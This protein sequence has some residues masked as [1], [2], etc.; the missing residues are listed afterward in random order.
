MTPWTTCPDHPRSR[1]VY[2]TAF[3]DAAHNR[4]SSPLARGLR[5]QPADRRDGPGI[6]PARAGF[7]TASRTTRSTTWDHP[8]S[9]GVYWR[10][11][12]PPCTPR[13]SSPLARGLLYSAYS[14]SHSPRIIPARAG[15]TDGWGALLNTV[16]DHPR[17]RG[18]YRR[19]GSRRRR[20]SGSSPLARGLLRDLHGEQRRVRIIPARAGYTPRGL[21]A[22][23]QRQDHPRLRGVY[24]VD[25][26]RLRRRRGS[27]PL[28]R[29]LHEDAL[30][31]LA[32]GGIIPARAG[33]AWRSRRR[34]RWR[35]DHPRSRGV[36]ASPRQS[37]KCAN[38]SSPLARGLPGAGPG[39]GTTMWI[40]PARAGFTGR[41]MTPAT[42]SPDHPRSRGVYVAMIRMAYVGWG[43]SPL[44]RG[45]RS[46]SRHP[47]P[48]EPDHPRSR[49]VYCT[50]P[51]SRWPPR[52]S[53][54]LARGLRQWI[55]ML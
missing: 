31:R 20:A 52:G 18:V 40:I 3:I 27:S 35:R 4:G 9:R 42:R 43:S 45:L 46:G 36:Y 53:S 13:G 8:R 12:W 28:A 10:A 14:H 34:R 25:L 55:S 51:G 5:H 1:G 17:S 54:P 21:P 47:D 22:L 49:G 39:R 11:A 37:T 24:G 33:F 48:P 26:G 30:A 44:A 38:G 50:C 19:P 16:G 32:D 29:G 15:S 23:R 41:G 7:T 2:A 6:I